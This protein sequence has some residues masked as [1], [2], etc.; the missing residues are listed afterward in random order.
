MFKANPAE[1]RH[2]AKGKLLLQVNAS[3]EG[4]E[5]QS[6]ARAASPNVNKKLNAIIKLLV[7]Q[8]CNYYESPQ[9]GWPKRTNTYSLK[10]SGGLKS[11]IKVSAGPAPSAVCSVGILPSLLSFSWL[12]A[13]LGVLRLVHAQTPS[14]PPFS[15]NLL[16][17]MSLRISS[18]VCSKGAIHWVRIHLNPV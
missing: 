5:G 15:H 14:Q 8:G 11:K 10:S 9:M 1:V 4:R 6:G 13:V 3:S 16:P 7:S 2:G 17:T 18:S 12:T